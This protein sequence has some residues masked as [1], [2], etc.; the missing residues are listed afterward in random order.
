[1]D[2]NLELKVEEAKNI[3]LNNFKSEEKDKYAGLFSGGKDSLIVYN[4]LKELNLTDDI[5]FLYNKSGMETEGFINFMNK[6]YP[7][8]NWVG[9]DKPLDE[10]WK[11]NKWLPEVRPVFNFENLTKKFI[12]NDEN[13]YQLYCCYRY[14]YGEKFKV[15]L[16]YKYVFT[17]TKNQDITNSHTIKSAVYSLHEWTYISPIYNW[18]N[19]ECWN[20]I[21]EKG[22]EYSIDYERLG[23]NYT[24]PLCSCMYNANKRNI[25][26][27]GIYYPELLQRYKDAAKYCYENNEKLQEIFSDWEDYFNC[28]LN[29]NEYRSRVFQRKE[30]IDTELDE[31]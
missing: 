11:E 19:N 20:Y 26:Q 8:V 24:C 10:I 18:T 23:G 22:I 9:P 21:N 3:I 5:Y 17:G 30:K 27:L 4:L 28:W 14:R 29:K 13:K 2:Q 16:N 7:N 1:M 25:V 12:Y 15:L 6:N 31:D